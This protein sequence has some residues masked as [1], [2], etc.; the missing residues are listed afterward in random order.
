MKKTKAQALALTLK[1]MW[2]FSVWISICLGQLL[3][4]FVSIY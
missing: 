4:T 1:D 2:Y 3:K